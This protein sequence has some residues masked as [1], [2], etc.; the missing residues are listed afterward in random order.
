MDSTHG[1]DYRNRRTRRIEMATVTRVF[2]P[3]RHEEL[4]R[5]LPQFFGAEGECSGPL[6]AYRTSHGIGHVACERHAKMVHVWSH[7]Y[8]GRGDKFSDFMRSLDGE[9]RQ[10]FEKCVSE[11]NLEYYYETYEGHM[12]K[13]R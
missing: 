7:C 5:T 1:N 6:L 8:N 12:E 10:K 4:V 3:C 9:A 2:K 13:V 11:C